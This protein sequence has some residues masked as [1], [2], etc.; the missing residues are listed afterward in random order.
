MA[1]LE[2]MMERQR[3]LA[4]FGELA[5]RSEDLD[6]VLTEAC[7][8]VARALACDLA[9]V[10]EVEDDGK[11]LVVRAGIGWQPGVI[12]ETRL[13]MTERS[14]ETYSIKVGVPVCVSVSIREHLESAE[15]VVIHSMAI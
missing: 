4:D 6:E 9:K 11:T 10:L 14:S 3:V 1:D 12:G 15:S 5:L 13:P 7:H 2:Q 8:L